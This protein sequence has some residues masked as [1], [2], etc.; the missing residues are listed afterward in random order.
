MRRSKGQPW[1]QDISRR[2]P[3]EAGVRELYSLTSNCSGRS[4]RDLVTYKLVVGVPEYE[5]RKLTI[6]VYN[7]FVPVVKDVFADGPSESPHRYGNSSLC[8]WYPDDPA[9]Q[10]WVYGDGLLQL[11]THARVH[12]FKEASWREHDQEDWPGEQAPHVNKETG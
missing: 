12:L 1:F 10:R 5:S 3:F 9:E 6:T 11:V 7:S 2:I 4:T 8:M